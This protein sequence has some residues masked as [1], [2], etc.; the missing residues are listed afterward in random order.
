LVIRLFQQLLHITGIWVK[1]STQELWVPLVFS[2][3]WS[4]DFGHSIE[5]Y[6]I[7]DS[8]YFV[9]RGS[10]NNPSIGT[11]IVVTKGSISINPLY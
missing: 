2:K 8:E 10:L 1:G 4:G 6:K 11:H 3:A 7:E 5:I 9:E